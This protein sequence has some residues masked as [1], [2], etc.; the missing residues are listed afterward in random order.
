MVGYTG[1]KGST[2]PRAAR[3]ALPSWGDAHVSCFQRYTE[4]VAATPDHMVKRGRL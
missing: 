1:Y 2:G 3:T 4:I